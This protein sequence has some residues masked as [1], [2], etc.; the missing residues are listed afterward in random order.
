MYF[1]NNFDNI[2]HNQYIQHKHNILRSQHIHPS[3]Q[4]SIQ[5]LTFNLKLKIFTLK[6]VYVLLY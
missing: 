2:L 1:I 4:L 5:S 3:T 6:R